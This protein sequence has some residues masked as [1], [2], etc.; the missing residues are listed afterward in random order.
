[1]EKTA[2][3]FLLSAM[4]VS[5]WDRW[6]VRISSE[7]RLP[8][9]TTQRGKLLKQPITQKWFEPLKNG[10]R[11]RKFWW[12]HFFQFE[13]LDLTGD[14]GCEGLQISQSRFILKSFLCKFQ[15]I[16]ESPL[17][18]T[19]VEETNLSDAYFQLLRQC[20][21]PCSH[22][23]LSMMEFLKH[24]NLLLFPLGHLGNY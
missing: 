2:I 7:Q 10:S 20:T 15:A 6:Q 4:S 13:P 1:M 21:A 19:H 18:S 22:L 17:K 3:M 9:T 8:Q 14:S 12:Y 24:H 16:K 5:G 23:S 11:G